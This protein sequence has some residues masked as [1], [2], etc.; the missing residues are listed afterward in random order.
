MAPQTKCGETL[1]EINNDPEDS[2]HTLPKSWYSSCIQAQVET[3]IEGYNLIYAY[4]YTV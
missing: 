1:A 2:A 4:N 3:I